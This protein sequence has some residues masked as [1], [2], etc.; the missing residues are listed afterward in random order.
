MRKKSWKKIRRKKLKTRKMKKVQ[1]AE[2]KT[3]EK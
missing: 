1:K 3:S 2:Q